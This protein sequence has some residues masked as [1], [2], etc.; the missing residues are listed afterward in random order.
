MALSKLYMKPMDMPKMATA[1]ELMQNF[2]CLS[3][4]AHKEHENTNSFAKH[5]ALGDFYE[6]VI[7]FKDRLGEYLI[8]MEYLS[9]I[10]LE[11]VDSDEDVLEEAMECCKLLQQFGKMNGDEAIIN[12]SGEF[13]EAIGKLKYLLR[14]P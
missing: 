7:A 9:K 4:T 5:E 3:V 13:K 14:F 1:E 8:G 12:M 6:K 2:Y 11:P 10:K